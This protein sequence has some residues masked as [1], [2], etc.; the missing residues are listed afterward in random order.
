MAL[1]K[2]LNAN[3][4]EE[5][6]LCVKKKQFLASTPQASDRD[7]HQKNEAMGKG[8]SEFTTKIK[9]PSPLDQQKPGLLQGDSNVAS[10]QNQSDTSLRKVS[11]Y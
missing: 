3:S 6:A 5:Q 8:S 9:F 7:N 4:D 2:E 10:F 1:N 11:S